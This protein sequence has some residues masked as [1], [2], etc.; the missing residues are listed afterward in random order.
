MKAASAQEIKTVLKNLEAKELAELCLRLARYKKENKELLTFLLF[1]ANDLA[2]YINGVNE[3]I[4]HAFTT[5]NTASVYFAKKGIRKALRMAN[6][7]IRYAGSKTTEVEILLHYCTN[8][9]GLKLSWQ[10]ST[11]LSNIYNAQIKKIAAAISTLH[12]DL[13]YDYRRTLQR[14]VE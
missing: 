9:K 1:E 10:R 3:E 7:Y 5:V 4:D 11:L 14:L 6:K 13:Q 12:E 8:F 2:G